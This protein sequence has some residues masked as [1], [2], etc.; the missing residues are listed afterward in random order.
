MKEHGTK[1]YF[2]IYQELAEI[3]KG[4]INHRT[5]KIFGYAYSAGSDVDELV[6]NVYAKYM[7]E[8]ALDAKAFPS[9]K[10]LEREVVRDTLNLLNAPEGAQGAFTVGGTESI[11]MGIRS[12][13]R[14]NQSLGKKGREVII[15]RT[16]HPAAIKACDYYDLTP[17]VVPV[18][19]DFRCNKEIVEKYITEDTICV[20]ASAPSYGTGVI[21]D[22]E[23]IASLVEGTSIQCIVDACMGGMILP[24]VEEDTPPWDLKSIF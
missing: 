6:E 8:N 11:M 15:P 10:N 1:D 13:K 17:V 18:G 24:F 3:A 23:G 19:E 12:A 5:G 9:V 20:I 22:I 21:D 4:D 14:Y 2:K 16:A 7:H